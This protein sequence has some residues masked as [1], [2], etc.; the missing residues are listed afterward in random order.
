VTNLPDDLLKIVKFKSELKQI[1]Q[2][3]AILQKTARYLASNL[4]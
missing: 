2:E 4:R 1:K 3:R